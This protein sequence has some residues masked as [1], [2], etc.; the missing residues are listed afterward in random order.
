[1]KPRYPEIEVELSGD[2]GN[3]LYVVGKV[4]RALRR[5]GIA[6]A[7]IAAFTTEATAGDYD[8]LLA[9]CMSWVEV[10]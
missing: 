1:M 4:R 3:A 10:S 6:A 8:Q 5:A 7:E 2:D 9:T